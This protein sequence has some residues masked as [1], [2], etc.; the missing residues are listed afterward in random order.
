MKFDRGLMKKRDKWRKQARK[1]KHPLD[2]AAC[3]SFR[4]EVKRELK[5]VEREYVAEQINKNPKNPRCIWKTIR[6]CVP[7]K[8][9]NQRTFSKDRRTVANEFNTFFSSVGQVT[10]DKINSL[11]NECKYNLAKPGLKP[12][13]Y[14]ESEQFA[15]HTVECKQIQNI[16]SA[17]PTNKAPGNDKIPMR[18][19]K[20]SLP[21]ILPTPRQ[22]STYPLLQ[23]HSLCLG[24]WLKSY[25]FQ[26]KVIMKDL[27]TIDLL[28]YWLPSLKG[29]KMWL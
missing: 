19:I 16:V 14:D 27:T 13:T 24:K 22:L 25:L 1:T 17:M 21:V 5:I 6:S 18:V 11:V 15:F 7:K 29:A 12:R 4:K 20:D 10:V 3:R 26:R 8:S 2:W 9:R 23:V 28:R